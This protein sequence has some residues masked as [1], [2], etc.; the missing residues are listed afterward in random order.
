[1]LAS[2][3]GAVFASFINVVAERSVNEVAWWGGA[4]SSCAAC[5]HVLAWFELVPVLSFVLQR[6]R[7]RACGNFIG[8]RYII[9]EIIGAS[10]GGLLAAR[11]GFSLA[12][13]SAFTASFFLLLNAL[14]D[15]QKGY[16]FDTHSFGMLLPAFLFRLYEGTL[17]DGAL[18]AALGFAI[19]A[20]IILVSR[21]GMGWGDASLMCGLGG[22]LGWKLTLLAFYLGVM[23]GGLCAVYLLIIGKVKWGAGDSIVLG[24]FLA[25]GGFVT[26]LCGSDIL[27]YVSSRL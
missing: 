3:F 24:P 8:A 17:L 10:I 27:G 1:M 18:G 7:C 21:G 26:L 23:S 14:T 2:V 12:F 13:F 11:W 6:G 25:F 22:F 15:Y 16:I 4:R 19:L 9:V 20:A 5:G